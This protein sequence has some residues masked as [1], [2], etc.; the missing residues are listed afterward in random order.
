MLK[1]IEYL[2]PTAAMRLDALVWQQL[3]GEDQI[4]PV[5]RGLQLDR[6]EGWLR[7]GILGAPRKDGAV[8]GRDLAVL[9]RVVYLSVLAIHDDSKPTADLQIDRRRSCPEG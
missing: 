8:W 5:A 2:A 3:V 6:H 9:S 7:A 4:G 1:S